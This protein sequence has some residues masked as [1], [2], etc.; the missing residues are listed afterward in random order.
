MSST[1]SDS[2]ADIFFKFPHLVATVNVFQLG[3]EIALKKSTSRRTRPFVTH[4]PLISAQFHL[5]H[6]GFH[7]KLVEK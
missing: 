2:F 4:Y 1:K 3:R 6:I 7:R 5:H